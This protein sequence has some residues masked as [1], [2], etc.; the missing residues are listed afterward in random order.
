M[1]LPGAG[2][3]DTPL[4]NGGSPGPWAGAPP[5]IG[6]KSGQPF[7]FIDYPDQPPSFQMLTFAASGS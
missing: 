2:F 4:E 5:L 1:W 3:A 7:Q 6:L